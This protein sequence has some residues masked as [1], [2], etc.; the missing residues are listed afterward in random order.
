MDLLL[1]TFMENNFATLTNSELLEFD[2]LL[3]ENELEIREWVIE[4][5]NIP[6][7]YRDLIRKINRS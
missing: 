3:N 5:K 1:S 7:H 6:A 2:N 4:E